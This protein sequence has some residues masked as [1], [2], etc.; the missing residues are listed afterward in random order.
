MLQIDLHGDLSGLLSAHPESPFLSLHHLDVTDP[1]F[2]SMNR[3]ESVVRLMEAAKLDQS[4][5]L[6]QTI[7]YHKPYN[8]SFS[9][10]WGYSIHIY[11]SIYPPSVLE[12]PLQ[13]FVPWKR[14]RMPPYMFNT[15]FPSKNPCEA[16]H[17][18]FF[19]SA[20]KIKG[21]QIVST[22]VRKFPRLLPA[23]SSSGNHSTDHISKVRV[24][25]PL[26]RL[27]GV[28]ISFPFFFF[29]NTIQIVS[30]SRSCYLKPVPENSF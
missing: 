25:S 12:R 28:S 2:P 17:V 20:E 4:R 26:T 9:I 29:L 11:E 16:P 7:C 14:I 24:F 6:Q 19:E 30:S 15:R 18:F 23:C 1:L 21:E 5:L 3:N 8:W 10:S 22:Y 27:H 13:T